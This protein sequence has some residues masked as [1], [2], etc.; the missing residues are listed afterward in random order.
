MRV[1]SRMMMRK[2]QALVTFCC[3]LSRC[4]FK[5]TGKFFQ[6]VLRC[7]KKKRKKIVT[8]ELNFSR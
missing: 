4:L 8:N 6:R 2:R 7:N 5:T 1:L 3:N